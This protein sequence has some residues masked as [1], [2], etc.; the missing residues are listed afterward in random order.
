MMEV[1]G[2]EVD[3]KME[4]QRN[5]GGLGEERVVD[6]VRVMRWNSRRWRGGS[7]SGIQ[8]RHL[9]QS[10]TPSWMLRSAQ[11]AR[12]FS[13]AIR[14]SWCRRV[15]VLR[16][17]RAPIFSEAVERGW[18]LSRCRRSERLLGLESRMDEREE[19]VPSILPKVEIKHQHVVYS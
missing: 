10:R 3:C 7:G 9:S 13:E 12:K 2:S 15:I 4:E 14:V 16:Q 19:L 8:S 18:Q 5:C 6:L 11:C 1:V 17:W